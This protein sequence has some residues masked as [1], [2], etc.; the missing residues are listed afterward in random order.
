VAV[1]FIGAGNR[2][3][4]RK[5]PNKQVIDKLYHI[6][7]ISNVTKTKL[8][9]VDCKYYRSYLKYY[10]PKQILREQNNKYKN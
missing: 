8:P 9:Q 1:S 5:P 7:L 4:R 6:I 3:T 2:S 10:I